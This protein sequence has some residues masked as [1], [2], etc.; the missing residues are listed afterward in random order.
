MSKKYLGIICLIYSGIFGYVVFFDKLTNFLAPQM[1][2]Y[3]K[4]S[5]I[6]MLVIGLILLFNKKNH[7]KFK[8]SDLILLVPLIILIIAGDGV[9]SSEFASNRAISTNKKNRIK[10]DEQYE[11]DEEY[12]NAEYDFTNPYFEIIDSNYEGLADY[13]TFAPKAEKFKGETIRVRGFIL[14]KAPYLPKGYFAI[15]KYSVSCCVAD[16]E[17]LGFVVKYDINKVI[18]GNWYEIEG[19]L[20]KGVD[21][22]G[23][24]MMFIKV[25][26]IKEIK[27]KGE[28]RYIYPCYNYAEGSCEAMAK[29]EMDY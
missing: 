22:E 4:L 21:A 16:A 5:I 6:P 9:L 13:I 3:V 14:K 25:V 24:S 2:L 7:Y 29:Y 10:Q 26:N 1:Q 12:L 19:I 23:Y 8:I 20:E 27:A 28:K 17:F 15:G 11:Y 18:E